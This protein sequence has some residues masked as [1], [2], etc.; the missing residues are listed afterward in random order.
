M[1]N[2]MAVNEDIP[3]RLSASAGLKWVT[4]AFK[5]FRK[6]PLL[7]S[8]TFGL[9]M[10][11]LIGVDLIPLIGPAFTEILTPLMVASFMAAFRALDQNDDLELPHF[12]AGLTT[13]PLPLAMVGALY[14]AALLLIGKVMQLLGLDMKALGEAT[15]HGDVDAMMTLLQQGGVALLIGVALLT[16]VLM[17]TWMA[18]PLILF[19]NAAPLQSL[20]ISLKACARNVLPLTVY[21]LVLLP[22]LLFAGMIPM[23]LGMLVAGPILMGS[24]YTAYQDIFAVRPASLETPGE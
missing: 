1:A 6:N 2:A 23:L 16:P 14:L 13:R 8:A 19:G 10:G 17:A 9:F 4:G 7:L 5:L 18:P 11:A 3:R 24:L 22:V 21:S 20:A 12:L 15:N